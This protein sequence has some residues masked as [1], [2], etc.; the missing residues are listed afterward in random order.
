MSL[1]SL[2]SLLSFLSF[3]SFVSLLSLLSLLTLTLLLFLA[4]NITITTSTLIRINKLLQPLHHIPRLKA[5]DAPDLAHLERRTDQH[6]DSREILLS[7]VAPVSHRFDT[8]DDPV[9]LRAE[10]VPKPLVDV[11][12]DDGGALRPPRPHHVHHQ[13]RQLFAHFLVVGLG[14][15]AD[16][17]VGFEEFRERCGERW[18]R[19]DAAYGV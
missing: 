17:V 7:L 11:L 14:V 12:R 6:G 8:R 5:R 1:L 9:V 18:D 16:A 2:L 4:L 3:L 10:T 13:V 19:G 15:V